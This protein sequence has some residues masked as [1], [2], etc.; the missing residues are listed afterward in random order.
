MAVRTG[1]RNSK[2]LVHGCGCGIVV[3]L[4]TGFVLG[5]CW[6]V[7]LLFGWRPA[8]DR[9]WLILSTAATL[10]VVVV[11]LLLIGY[12]LL[13][14][15]APHPVPRRLYFAWLLVVLPVLAI[16]TIVSAWICDALDAS[17][18][19]RYLGLGPWLA[20]LGVAAAAGLVYSAVVAHDSKLSTGRS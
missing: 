8:G 18:A 13:A 16:L 19:A 14:D 10:A 3:V 2:G 20:G 11:A 5:L 4:L 6:L 9:G 17:S 12:M 7:L 15:S 1:F